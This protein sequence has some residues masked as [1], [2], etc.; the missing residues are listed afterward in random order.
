[1][2]EYPYN[3]YR[4]KP[5]ISTMSKK[6][7]YLCIMLLFSL[8]VNVVQAQESINSS[9]GIAQGNSGTT[10]Y[11]IGQV[12]YQSYADTSGNTISEGA[13]QPFEISILLSTK[14][15]NKIELVVA[16]FPN[17]TTNYLTMKILNFDSSK[18]QYQLFDISG[19]LLESEKISAI[20]TKI[21]MN[22]YMASTYII[23]VFDKKKEI[24]SFKIIKN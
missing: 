7:Q 19:K 3:E 18:L 20:E 4:S 24:K 11:S 10:T 2:K 13:Q 1:M 21:N 5:K 17:P 9:N 15:A 12:F 23:K 22:R 14:K 6:I 16:A 8:T